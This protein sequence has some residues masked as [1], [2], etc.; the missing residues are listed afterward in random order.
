MNNNFD[1]YSMKW[2]PIPFDHS[3]IQSFE[4]RDKKDLDDYIQKI[5]KFIEDNKD[6]LFPDDYQEIN[7][8]FKTV[9]DVKDIPSMKKLADLKKSCKPDLYKIIDKFKQLKEELKKEDPENKK[10]YS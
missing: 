4:E 1:G 8:K 5:I 7:E 3:R 2:S 6:I 10:K 9:R